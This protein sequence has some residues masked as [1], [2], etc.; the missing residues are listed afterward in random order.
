[1]DG[2]VVGSPRVSPGIRSSHPFRWL[3]SAGHKLMHHAPTRRLALVVLALSPAWLLSRGETGLVVAVAS[4]ALLLL[5]ALVDA[6]RIPPPD[7]ILVTRTVPGS[8]GLGDTRAA[9]YT[10]GSSWPRAVR[11]S[12]SHRM[13][14]QL[15]AHWDSRLEVRSDSVGESV[16]LLLLPDERTTVDFT[17]TGRARGNAVLGPVALTVPGPWGLVQRSIIYLPGDTISII[18]AV[19]S[20]GRYRLLAAQQRARSAGQ[21]ALRR[22]GIGTSFAALRDYMPGDDPRRID[23]KA[24][25]RRDRLI[26]R[27]F[28]V[29]QG[30]T[31][32]IAIDAGRMMTQLSGEQSRFEY[33]LSAALTLADVALSTGDRV[34]VIVFGTEVQRYLPPSREPGM[35]G[36]IRDALTGVEAS[37]DEPDYAAAFRTMVQRNRR[38]SLIV[39][40]TDVVDPRSSRALIALTARSAERHLPLVVA[41]HNEELA[42]AAI[43]RA[44]GSEEQGYRSAAAEE[45]LLARDSA[46]QQMRQAGVAVLDAAPRAMTAA[47]I[48]RYLEIKERSEL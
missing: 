15:Q 20:A 9:S 44:D 13:P 11:G 5:A 36:A 1:M 16:Q 26:T 30:Q 42:A 34:G 17:V 48:N 37:V 21:R 24:T 33:A 2:T 40:F 23:W 7:S 29:E 18:P 45:L 4:V 25:A 19:R 27:E 35:L 14:P 6:L 8:V 39:L 31:V 3:V 38:R 10:I 22:R 47:L 46:L 28:S 41:M 43:P 12:L 32:M